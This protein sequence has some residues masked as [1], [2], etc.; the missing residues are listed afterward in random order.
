MAGLRTLQSGAAARRGAIPGSCGCL[1][2]LQRWGRWLA[3]HGSKELA[4][5]VQTMGGASGLRAGPPPPSWRCRLTSALRTSPLPV[6][7]GSSSPSGDAA[8]RPTPPVVERY[9]LGSSGVRVMGQG[10]GVE[11]LLRHQA[12]PLVVAELLAKAS[13]DWICTWPGTALL[14]LCSRL[15]CLA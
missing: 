12:W 14:A 11:P 3:S 1:G 6:R 5:W 7:C 15:C 4:V 8:L 9:S 2:V 10:A 13:G